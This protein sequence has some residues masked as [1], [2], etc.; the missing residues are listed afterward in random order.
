MRI[1]ESTTLWGYLDLMGFEFEAEIEVDIYELSSPE[2]GLYGPPEFYDPGSSADF[3]ITSIILRE[4]RP[5]RSG[6]AFYADGALFE[7]LADKFHSLAQD[8]ANAH[9]PYDPREDY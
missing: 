1:Y 9:E 6:P 5:G 7:H 4:D 8:A 2:S 3:A